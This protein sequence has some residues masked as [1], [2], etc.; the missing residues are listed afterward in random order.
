MCRSLDA[1]PV[2]RLPAMVAV[3]IVELVAAVPHHPARTRTMHRTLAVVALALLVAGCARFGTRANGPFFS[4]RPRPLAAIPPA[5]LANSSPLAIPND[6]YARTPGPAAPRR[7][8]IVPAGGPLLEGDPQLLPFRRPDPT[9][10]P[11]PFAPKDTPPP[12][13]P[14]PVMPEVPL[15]MAPAAATDLQQIKNLVR[16]ANEMW[17]KVDAYECVATRREFT[18]T[19]EMVEDVTL[20]RFRKEPMAVYMKTTSMP[21]KG[22]EMVY[23]PSKHGDKIYVVLGEGDSRIFRAGFKAP[24]VSPDAAIVKEKSRYS[25][26]E[27][28][29]A[30]PIKR[31]GSWVVKV[32]TGKIPAQNLRYLGT[33]NRKEIPH[34][35]TGVEL[36]LRPGD[37]P[38]M[39]NGGTRR[40]FFDTNPDSPACGFPVL[41]IATEPSGKEVEYYLIEKVRTDVKFTD[42]DFAPR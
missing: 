10:L 17:D 34:A 21:G 14:A 8:A 18:P 9:K 41:I 7:D 3:C 24:P 31:V 2:L 28:G 38:L 1:Q 32:E 13:A 5:P 20:Y 37:D 42:M 39:P 33:V 36:T 6:P 19:K 22:R 30:T 26:R 16:F 35:L 12:P 29:H 40:W 4:Q 11:S 23:N 15:P 25:I 27:A